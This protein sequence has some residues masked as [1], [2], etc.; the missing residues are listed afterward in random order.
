LLKQKRTLKFFLFYR[1]I[2]FSAILVQYIIISCHSSIA[3][4]QHVSLVLNINNYQ[5]SPDSWLR[6]IIWFLIILI[7]YCF[8]AFYLVVEMVAHA[9]TLSVFGRHGRRS[10]RRAAGTGCPRSTNNINPTRR[11]SVPFTRRGQHRCV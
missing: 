3:Y 1:Y 8:R 6:H 11:R 10:D 9:G 2:F 5:R 4:I 7:M